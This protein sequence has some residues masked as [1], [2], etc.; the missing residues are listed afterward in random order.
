MADP[1]PYAPPT[2]NTDPPP[3]LD[4]SLDSCPR[5]KSN[6]VN[7]PKFTWWGGAVGPRLLSHAVCRACGLGYNY[8][9]G[10]PNTTAITIY[11]VVVA[12][13]AF[14]LSAALMSR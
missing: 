5:C 8:K 14:G 11:V 1:N 2:T 12:V 10:K 7:R 3:Q 9:T 6:N 13:I 4:A